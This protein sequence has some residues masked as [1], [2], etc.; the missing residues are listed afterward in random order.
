MTYNPHKYLS[1]KTCCFTGHR[2]EKLPWRYNENDS[3]CIALKRKIYDI[4]EAVYLSGVTHFICGMAKGCDMYFCEA[5]IELRDEYPNITL[6]AAIPCETQA[7]GW[8][9]TDRNRYYY[10]ASQCDDETMLQRAYSPDC[11]LKR[12]MY[13]VDNSS[14]LIAV[15]SGSFGG[16][17]QT[18]NYA[19]RRGLEIISIDPLAEVET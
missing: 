17:M 15:Y 11:M 13:M 8:S 14:V 7:L 9:E 5:V 16:T 10:L 6:E 4:I 18:V 2:P 12:N 19:R 1:S 3:R